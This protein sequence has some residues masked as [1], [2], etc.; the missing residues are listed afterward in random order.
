MS[1]RRRQR[2]RRRR[3]ASQRL[4]ALALWLRLGPFPAELLDDRAVDLDAGRRSPRRA[5]V[6]GAVGRRHAQR[7]ADRRRRCR[8]CSSR[9]R[10]RPRTGGSGRIPASIRSRWLRASKA[11]LAERRVVEGGSTITQQVAKLLL[12]R[13]IAAARA[14]AGGEDPR[15]GDRAAARAPVHQARDPRA[16]SEPGGAT[17][18]RSPASSA[19]AARTS[20]SP[21]RC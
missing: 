13:R 12:N 20:A 17:A 19:R 1:S 3:L 15:S 21:R 4:V 8:P 6:R 16:V 18:T 11:N 5:A 10:S 9:R 7:D 14:A 2:A